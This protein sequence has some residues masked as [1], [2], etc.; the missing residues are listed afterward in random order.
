MKKKK[1]MAFLLAFAMIISLFSGVGT[2]KVEAA[3]P[4]W[5]EVYDKASY[6]MTSPNFTMKVGGTPVDVVQ[7]FYKENVR[8]GYSYA[9]LA[10]EGTATFEITCLQGNIEAV[11]A[12]PHSY[13]MDVKIDGNKFTFD[14]D[15]KSVV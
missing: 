14:L 13:N 4:T 3:T 12:S 15:R 5:I 9:H 10:Y 8:V 7:Y 2:M 11:D 6:E 1:R